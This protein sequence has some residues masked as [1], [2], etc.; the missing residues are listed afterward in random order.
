MAC[1]QS[2][3]SAH[4]IRVSSVEVV[5]LNLERLS[6]KCSTTNGKCSFERRT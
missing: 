2:I 4:K 5:A 6:Q 3:K 1:Y